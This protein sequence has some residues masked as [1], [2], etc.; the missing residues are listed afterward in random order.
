MERSHH[1]RKC[2]PAIPIDS[3]SPAS[4]E[5]A[6]FWSGPT[7]DCFCLFG[8][9]RQVDAQS[10]PVG[11]GAVASACWFGFIR[12]RPL[13][14]SMKSLSDEE[15]WRGWTAGFVLLLLPTLACECV[16]IWAVVMKLLC[17]IVSESFVNTCVCVCWGGTYEW[18]CWVMA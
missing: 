13:L 7:V 2:P 10:V 5:A 18:D 12:L 6:I 8:D 3:R 4:P 14:R 1:R 9:S 15:S 16:F 17:T 11:V